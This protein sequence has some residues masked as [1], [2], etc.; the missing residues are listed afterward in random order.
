VE[1]WGGF[2]G[3]KLAAYTQCTIEENNVDTTVT[4]FS[5]EFFRLHIAHAMIHSLIMHYVVSEGKIL[6]NGE[7]S[8]AHPTNFQDFLIQFGFNKMFCRLNIEY[9]WLLASALRVGQPLRKM[10]PS[11]TGGF[12]GKLHALMAQEEIRKSCCC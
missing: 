2:V 3:D 8:I 6:S 7:R 10:V 11:A 5:P 4:R 1:Y 12:L 9:R